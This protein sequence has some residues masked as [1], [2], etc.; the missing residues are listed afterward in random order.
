LRLN[1]GD[2]EARENL[3]KALLELKRR[4]LLKNKK[5]KRSRAAKTTTQTK[6][7]ALVKQNS[8]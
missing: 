7:I 1:P 8:N 6:N 3:Q 2:Q 5:R 4:T